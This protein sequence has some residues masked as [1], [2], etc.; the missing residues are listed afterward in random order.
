M[1]STTSG[2]IRSGAVSCV[3]RL[4]DVGGSDFLRRLSSSDV[5]AVCHETVGGDITFVTLAE[6]KV[7]TG[8]CFDHRSFRNMIG[9]G[10]ARALGTLNCTA[11]S[12]ARVTLGRISGAMLSLRG[13]GH[14][15]TGSRGTRCAGTR[16]GGVRE[17]I[18]GSAGRLRGAKQ[19]TSARLNASNARR[20]SVRRV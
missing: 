19:D 1:V 15:V 10:A 17:D 7:G 12:V 6:L 2:T 3:T 8:R 18:S 11:D 4:P 13:S 20:F 5:S 16:G 14:V 9:F